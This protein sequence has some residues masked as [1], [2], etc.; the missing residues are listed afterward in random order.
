MVLRRRGDAP[1]QQSRHTA[2]RT[3]PALLLTRRLVPHGP[4]LRFA[5]HIFDSKG[6]LS[7]GGVRVRLLRLTCRA[8]DGPV[9]P[10]MTQ[11]R[12]SLGS[13]RTVEKGG[14]WSF[15]I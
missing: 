13:Q 11:S 2:Q 1:P 9:S 14:Y 5:R 6:S 7:A 8:A 10:K 4:R 3:D 15:A 12:P